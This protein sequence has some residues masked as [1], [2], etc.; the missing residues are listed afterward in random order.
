MRY[1]AEHKE[2]TRALLLKEAAR[3]IRAKGPQRIG[4]AAIMAK[5]GLTHGGFYAHFT[6]K[7]ELVAE[8]VGAMFT[9]SGTRLQKMLSELPPDEALAAYADFYLS[10]RHR[11]DRGRGCPIPALSADVPHLSPAARRA[12]GD[13]IAQLGNILADLLRRMNHPQPVQAASSLLSELSGALALARCL[14]SGE[15][16]DALLAASRAALA[17]RFGLVLK[18]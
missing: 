15:Q 5:A 4:V 12:F 16:S 6:S 9:D 1:D 3:A 8:A 13:G 2:R 11:D 10:P 17:Q 18:H 14:G 7:D